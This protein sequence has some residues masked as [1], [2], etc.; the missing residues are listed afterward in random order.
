MLSLFA[1]VILLPSAPASSATTPREDLKAVV[2]Q[3]QAK[4][5]DRALREKAI[6]LARALK[7]APKV[8]EEAERK[9]VMGGTF[10]KE[11]KSAE[12]SG[13]AISAFQDALKIAPWWGDAYYNLSVSLESAGR[14]AEAK[15]AL[16]LYLLTKPKDAADAKRRLYALEA[17]QEMA[18]KQAAT[19][20]AAEAAAKTKHESSI[21]GA[22]FLLDERGTTWG[23]PEL[24]VRRKD[25]GF[26]I[27][28]NYAEGVFQ[29]SNVRTTETTV[30][31][32][33]S[34][35]SNKTFDFDLHRDGADMAGTR[36]EFM[37]PPY[38]AEA[39]RLV[40]KPWQGVP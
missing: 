13:S 35:G 16:E 17:R 8:P 26:E 9:F 20:A 36:T 27:K 12:D 38:R 14:F 10:Q 28:T 6:A 40:R 37:A 24:I 33:I 25:A 22:W 31:Y 34:S 23:G 7:P 30:A 15:D 4:P 29:T 2:A 11:A 3:I 5:G 1:A 39:V 19:A 18:G 32:S 21:E